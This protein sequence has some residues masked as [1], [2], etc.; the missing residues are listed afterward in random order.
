MVAWVK[1]IVAKVENIKVLPPR[2]YNRSKLR[3]RSARPFTAC[4]R[5]TAT[6]K[7]RCGAGAKCNACRATLLTTLQ[8][9]VHR[10]GGIHRYRLSVQHI[11]L[12][13]PLPHGVERRLHQHGVSAHYFEV[14]N[15]SSF[16]DERVQY[17]LSL[18]ARGLGQRRIERL[19][20]ADQIA[21]GDALRDANT[22]RRG[23][24]GDIRRSDDAAQNA[25][26]RSSGYTTLDTADDARGRWRRLFFFDY[27][28][29]LWDLGGGAQLA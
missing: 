11:R 14:F 19:H 3:F 20:L 21:L 28:Y 1:I 16:A 25:A 4:R 15:V 24:L 26:Q 5:Q 13:L 9:K 12:V 29:F 22:A 8:V 18:N 6:P 7:D 10:N 27:F 17:H 2:T 23:H